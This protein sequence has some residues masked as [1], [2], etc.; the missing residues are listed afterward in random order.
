MHTNIHNRI[1]QTI[2]HSDNTNE[3]VICNNDNNYNCFCNNRRHIIH[4]S[5]LH[6][7]CAALCIVYW[8]VLSC[9]MFIGIASCIC[10][11]M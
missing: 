7:A 3:N 4:H 9:A 10:I 5:V 2:D 11:S 6:M 1:N 8:Y